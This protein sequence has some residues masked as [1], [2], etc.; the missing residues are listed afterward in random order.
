[1][2]SGLV[3]SDGSTSQSADLSKGEPAAST[4]RTVQNLVLNDHQLRVMRQDNIRR[5]RMLPL[6]SWG[7]Y[8]QAIKK[9]PQHHAKAPCV[10]VNQI[11]YWA[12]KYALSIV[13]G[14]LAEGRNCFCH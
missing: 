6:C 1:M 13:R 2:S 10:S 7:V 3:F 11:E 12:T 14:L 8:F 4:Q 5:E 9:E